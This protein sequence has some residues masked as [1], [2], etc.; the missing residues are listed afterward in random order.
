MAYHKLEVGA[1][2]AIRIAPVPKGV[3]VSWTI[4][5]WSVAGRVGCNKPGNK[6]LSA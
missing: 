6:L 4:A 2:N 3:Y 5:N 1:G